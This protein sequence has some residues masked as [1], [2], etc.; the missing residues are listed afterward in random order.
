MENVIPA[1]TNKL[2]YLSETS[3]VVI[4]FIGRVIAR[5]FTAITAMNPIKLRSAYDIFLLFLSIFPPYIFN[6]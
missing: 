2:G 1:G 5:V 3:P 6:L 4:L